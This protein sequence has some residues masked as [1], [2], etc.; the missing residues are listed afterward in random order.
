MQSVALRCPVTI[1]T[2]HMTRLRIYNRLGTVDLANRF[3]RMSR[4]CRV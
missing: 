4:L 3:P 1:V 2:E